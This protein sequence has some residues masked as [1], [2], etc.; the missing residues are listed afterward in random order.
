MTK[1]S[2]HPCPVKVSH[3]NEGDY[4]DDSEDMVENDDMYD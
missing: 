4:Y 3:T 2:V 1:Y